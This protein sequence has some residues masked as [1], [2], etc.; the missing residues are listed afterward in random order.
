M[1]VRKFVTFKTMLQKF[2]VE[3]QVICIKFKIAK[4]EILFKRIFTNYR[5]RGE[6][7][8][9]KNV[10]KFSVKVLSFISKRVYNIKYKNY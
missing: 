1:V 5:G 10:C 2:T 4:I 8:G 6:G 3:T 9:G 7:E